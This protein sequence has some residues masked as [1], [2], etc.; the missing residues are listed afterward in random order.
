MTASKLGAVVPEGAE[1]TADENEL[2]ETLQARV[3]DY[4]KYMNEMEFRKAVAELRAI[5]V[6]GNNY[7]TK[8]E[9]WTVIKED[10]KR[11][12][13]I[14]KVCLNLIR[15]MAILSAPIMP[16]TAE[17][18]LAKFSLS[19]SDMP[20]LKDFDIKKE[21]TAL[22]AGKEFEVGDALFERITPEKI[23]ELKQKYGANS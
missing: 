7:I 18:M 1:F 14:L 19:A 11:A 15:I 13:T 12:E 23:D 4:F 3:N 16:D 5:W 17:K 6:E 2:I 20:T 21:I 9:P 10:Q 22:E 8:T